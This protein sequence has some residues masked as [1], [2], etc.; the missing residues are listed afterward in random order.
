MD[1]KYLSLTSYRRDGTG[2]AT[3]LWFAQDGDRL[4]VSTG[5]ASWKVKRIRR[6]PRV[7]VAPCG[8][9]GRPRGE[10]VAGT[11]ALASDEDASRAH[12][13][14]ARKYKYDRLWA[15]PLFRLFERLRGHKPST[16]EEVV[17]TITLGA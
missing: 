7:T 16:D 2:V 11:A 17:L 14:F 1:G 13:L 15:L 9:S 5:A 12:A 3:P 6:D 8:P 10:P 4:F